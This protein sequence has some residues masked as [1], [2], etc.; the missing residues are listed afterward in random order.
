MGDQAASGAAVVSVLS[1]IAIPK[2]VQMQYKAKHGEVLANM[3]AIQ[4]ALMIYEANFDRYI[5][6]QAHP[7]ALEALNGDAVPWTKGSDFDT[8]GWAP[9]GHVRGTY[10]VEIAEDG[11]DFTIWGAIDLDA[12]GEA[13]LFQATKTTPPTKV[14][15]ENTY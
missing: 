8:L 1:A 9:D 6:I 10:W 12:N 2:F 5:P 4:T 3:G 14:T 7:R 11:T 13:A 15:R